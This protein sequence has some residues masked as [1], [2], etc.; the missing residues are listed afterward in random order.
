MV[1]FPNPQHLHWVL[2][3]RQWQHQPP[4]VA[5]PKSLRQDLAHFPPQRHSANPHPHSSS[6]PY[7]RH[8]P[9]PRQRVSVSPTQRPPRL[10]DQSS[11]VPPSL[12]RGCSI[13]LCARTDGGRWSNEFRFFGRSTREGGRFGVG[14]KGDAFLLIIGTEVWWWVDGTWGKRFWSA[15]LEDGTGGGL[16]RLARLV[17]GGVW[18]W[19]V[20]HGD[21]ESLVELT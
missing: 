4:K 9:T 18:G 21:I 10:S 1:V 5:S 19:S 13:R 14:G 20:F 12:A 11:T 8:S 17:G 16:L 2:A 15:D 3:P 6:P 7:L